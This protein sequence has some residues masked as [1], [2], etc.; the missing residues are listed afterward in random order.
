MEVR[1][2]Y[3]RPRVVVALPSYNHACRW[4][5]SENPLASRCCVSCHD[6]ENMGYD[7]LGFVM[8]GDIDVEMCC[9][10]G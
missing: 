6:D 5:S 8:V 10:Y 7:Q 9:A 1:R 4:C 2:L 3:E